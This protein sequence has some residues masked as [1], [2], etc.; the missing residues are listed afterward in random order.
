[1]K[2]LNFTQQIKSYEPTVKVLE[3]EFAQLGN[4]DSLKNLRLNNKLLFNK[5]IKIKNIDFSYGNGKKVFELFSDNIKKNDFVGIIGKSGSGKSTLIDLITGLVSPDSGE[6]LVD[7][8]EIR[9]NLLNWQKKIGYVPQ[10]IFLLD[11]TIVENVAFGEN[12]AEVDLD[13]VKKALAKA[14][15]LKFVENLNKELET[16]VGE[17]GIQLS[18]GQK[19]RIAIARELYRDPELLVLDESTSALDEETENHILEFLENLRG[20]ITVIISSQS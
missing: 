5:E 7:G 19:Q 1:M 11:A 20:R 17:R 15:I 16:K 2:I 13:K 4:T 3:K 10:N 6:I 12:K 18:G 8:V 14:Q 9:N